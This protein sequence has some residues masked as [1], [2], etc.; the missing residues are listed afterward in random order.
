MEW[1]GWAAW[2]VSTIAAL[3]GLFFGI[4][5]ER[6]ASYNPL[7]VLTQSQEVINRTG[8][9]AGNVLVF[10]QSTTTGERTTHRAGSV[11]PDGA[12]SFATSHIQGAREI[13][14]VWMR[15]TT[16]RMYWWPRSA[17]FSTRRIRQ[18]HRGVVRDSERRIRRLPQLGELSPEASRELRW[19]HWRP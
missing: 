8:E 1:W 13:F 17:R 2:A 15:P 4:R 3:F 5:A 9:D 18:H 10:V 6:R 14:V 12:A 19:W 16:N 7:W 11:A